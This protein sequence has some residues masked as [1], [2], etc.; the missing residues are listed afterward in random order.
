MTSPIGAAGH[1]G[2]GKFVRNGFYGV[3]TSTKTTSFVMRTTTAELP[4][5]ESL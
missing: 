5:T 3:N 1:N 4:G 2:V